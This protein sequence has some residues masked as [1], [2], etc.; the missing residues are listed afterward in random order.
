MTSRRRRTKWWRSTTRT[1]KAPLDTPE[2]KLRFWDDV[3][4]Q[5]LADGY[6]G[7]RVLAEVTRLAMDPDQL[8]E[9][10]R[11]EHLADDYIANGPGLSA[12]CAYRTDVLDETV[13]RELACRHPQVREPVQEESFRLFFDGDTLVLAGMLDSFNAEQLERLLAGTHVQRDRLVL[14]VSQLEFV[15]GR[16]TTVLAELALALSERKGML[17]IVGASATLQK[18]WRVLGY[19][20]L[21]N[22]TLSG[23]GRD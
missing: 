22:V 23:A 14:D 16:G 7:L 9:H 6:T 4:R 21:T 2:K 11:W 18:I 13:I 10:L 3:T 8:D 17:R 12:V 20:Q 5:A 1:A 19:S 15:D